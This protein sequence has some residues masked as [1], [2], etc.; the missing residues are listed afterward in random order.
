MTE[1]FLAFRI[2]EMNNSKHYVGHVDCQDYKNFTD[3]K[4]TPTARVSDI[5]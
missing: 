1:A 5:C 3:L 4:D 2:R